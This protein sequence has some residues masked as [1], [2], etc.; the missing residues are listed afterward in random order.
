M[1]NRIVNDEVSFLMLLTYK[2]HKMCRL[3]IDLLGS[4]GNLGIRFRGRYSLNISRRGGHATHAER[5]PRSRSER[6][7]LSGT[8]DR[9]AVDSSK[10]H[11]GGRL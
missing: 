7:E 9:H 3:G 1:G 4:F 10:S 5:Q 2:P 8:L 6:I 11:F